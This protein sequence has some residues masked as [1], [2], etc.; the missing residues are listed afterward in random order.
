M[1]EDTLERSQSITTPLNRDGLI[2]GEIE[3]RA[4]R[5]ITLTKKV[6]CLLTKRSE[7]VKVMVEMQEICD[8]CKLYDI[9]PEIIQLYLP[10]KKCLYKQMPSMQFPTNEQSVFN[11]I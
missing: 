1:T 4:A 6:D 8:I 11:N 9:S 3:D 10:S 2:L 7:T 5:L